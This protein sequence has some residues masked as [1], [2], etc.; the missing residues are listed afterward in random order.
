MEIGSQINVST[1]EGDDEV[2]EVTIGNLP[3]DA[4]FNLG[5]AELT[6]NGDGEIVLSGDDLESFLADQTQLTMTLPQHSDADVS[7]VA[8]ARSS[9]VQ[10]MS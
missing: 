3:G 10:L 7:R 1:V 2:T 8:T 5:G 4:T 6:A 9:L